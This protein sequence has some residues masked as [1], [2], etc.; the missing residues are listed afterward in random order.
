[1]EQ[2]LG[3]PRGLS[4]QPLWQFLSPE[5]AKEL[6]GRVASGSRGAELRFPLTF[7][8]AGS[9]EYVLLCNLDV[10][11][12]AFALLCEPVSA[13]VPAAGSWNGMKGGPGK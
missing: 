11:P 5:S 6:R 10:Q 2:L 3:E 9:G 8:G 1:M 7:I 13:A 4:G 12:N